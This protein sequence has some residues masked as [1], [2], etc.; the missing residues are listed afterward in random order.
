M[1]VQPEHFHEWGTAPTRVRVRCLQAEAERD[2]YR[3][4]LERCHRIL[5]HPSKAT[6]RDSVTRIIDEALRD[7]AT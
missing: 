4:V 3:A 5:G 1:S 6:P 2:R 7:G